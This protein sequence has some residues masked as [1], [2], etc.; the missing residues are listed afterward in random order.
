MLLA[1][2]LL[3]G[4]FP[5]VLPV[6]VGGVEDPA[7]QRDGLWR[8]LLL[9]DAA[10]SQIGFGG[11]GWRLWSAVRDVVRAVSGNVVV[12]GWT[13][14]MAV[15]PRVGVSV[16]VC[17]WVRRRVAVMEGPNRVH[18]VNFWSAVV[19]VQVGGG[20]VLVR[21]GPQVTGKRLQGVIPDGTGIRILTSKVTLTKRRNTAA[22]AARQGG[23]TAP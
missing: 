12:G 21:G 11:H 20:Q 6:A 7:G 16:R 15:K 18:G 22:S 19:H 17:V 3:P 8:Q 9:W 23:V 14:G 2:A 13:M 4:V 1:D 10:L 5:G